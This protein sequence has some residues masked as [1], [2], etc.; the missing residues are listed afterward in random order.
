MAAT[1][2]AYRSLGYEVVCQWYKIGGGGK[3]KR[4]LE[5]TWNIMRVRKGRL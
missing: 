5:W 3:G 2:R 4:K 1:E